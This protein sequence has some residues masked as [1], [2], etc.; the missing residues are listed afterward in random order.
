MTSVV[1]LVNASRAANEV[2]H[3]VREGLI[4]SHGLEMGVANIFPTFRQAT[5]VNSDSYRYHDGARREN[6]ALPKRGE[7][8]Q[9]EE[10]NAHGMQ[11]QQV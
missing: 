11:Y 4:W 5:L 10:A 8:L 9:N 6:K 3:D 2:F 7:K 1:D